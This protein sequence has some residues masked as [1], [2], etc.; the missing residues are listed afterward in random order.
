MCSG[1]GHV[2]VGSPR[3]VHFQTIEWDG[4]RNDSRQWYVVF[5]TGQC[6]RNWGETVKT[7]TLWLESSTWRKQSLASHTASPVAPLSPA[8]GCG[9][10]WPLSALWH[11]LN[12]VCFIAPSAHILTLSSAPPASRMQLKREDAKIT[13]LAFLRWIF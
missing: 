6:V 1:L 11:L 12:Y 8:H 9:R 2:D 4:I 13:F 3:P 5:L 10:H 7:K